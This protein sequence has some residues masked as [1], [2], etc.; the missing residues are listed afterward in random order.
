MGHPNVLRRMEGDIHKRA[1]QPRHDPDM[2]ATRMEVAA[3][4]RGASRKLTPEPP[5]N[6]GAMDSITYRNF[7][8]ENYGYDPGT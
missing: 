3:A 8:K 7:A 2:T 4:V 5:P 6:F 1:W